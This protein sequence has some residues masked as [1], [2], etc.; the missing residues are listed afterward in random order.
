MTTRGLPPRFDIHLLAIALTVAATERPLS[1]ADLTRVIRAFN[2]ILRRAQF[3]F[4]DAVNFSSD[5]L[6]VATLLLFFFDMILTPLQ[7]PVIISAR[8]ALSI[9]DVNAHLATADA[10]LTFRPFEFL[11][12]AAAQPVALSTDAKSLCWFLFSI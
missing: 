10:A 6:R 12:D 2:G 9:A 3:R 5:Q 7:W 8:L 1:Y 4:T 11:E